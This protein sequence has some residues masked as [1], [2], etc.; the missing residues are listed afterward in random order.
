MRARLCFVVKRCTWHIHTR[1]EVPPGLVHDWAFSSGSGREGRASPPCHSAG[2]LGRRRAVE[3]HGGRGEGRPAT[4][5][6]GA[7]PGAV[8][9]REAAGVVP[10][11]PVGAAQ[12]IRPGGQR[13][14]P[15]ELGAGG[16]W[17]QH[18]PV[19]GAV[20]RPGP[21]LAVSQPLLPGV[22]RVEVLML[23]PTQLLRV[24]SMLARRHQH[25][26]R[27]LAVGDHRVGWHLM[28]L[29][30]YCSLCCGMCGGHCCCTCASPR[31]G[32]R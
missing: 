27:V 2:W 3:Q 28:G 21:R 19:A 30:S 1:G 20:R 17:T 4:A 16:G 26:K 29:I 5:S 13:A 32:E 7:G 15:E 23:G 24:V 6:H 14:V 18:G 11:E 9:S 31:A 22:P 12:R 25:F 10:G 8:G